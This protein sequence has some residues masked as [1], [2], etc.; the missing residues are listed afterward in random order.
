M[1]GSKPEASASHTAEIGT[2]ILVLGCPGSGKSTFARALHRKTGLPLFHLDNLWWKADRT[3]ISREEFDL[4]LREILAERQWILDG[5]YSRTWEVR[6][7]ACDTAFLFDLPEEECVEGVTGRTGCAR[8]DLPWIETE[9]DPQLLALVRSY[10]TE[11][12]PQLQDLLRRHPHV[13][14]ICFDSR[15]E[16]DRFADSAAPVQLSE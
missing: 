1:T 7:S 16:A 13:R 10:R 3:H 6:I 11:K 12:L 8:P 2:R 15:R 4:R 9:A 5:D 14:V